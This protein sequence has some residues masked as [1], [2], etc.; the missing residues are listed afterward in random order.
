MLDLALER[1]SDYIMNITIV[2]ATGLV[3]EVFLDLLQAAHLP[4]DKLTLL[5]GSSAGASVKFADQDYT[6]QKLSGHDFAGT[7][8]VVFCTSAELSKIYVPLAARSGA[9]VIDLS[10]RFR[11]DA[12]VPLVIPEINA[13]V[14][15]ACPSSRVIA[16]PNCSTAQMLLPLAPLESS[17]GLRSINV[18]T[19]QSAS[20]AGRQLLSSIENNDT[21]CEL[22]ANVIAQIDAM[23]DNGYTREELKMRCETQKIFARPDL[24]ISATCVRVPVAIG[25]SEALQS[26]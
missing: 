14:L 1:E 23:T 22:H 24:T 4:L 21:S 20:G 12:A 6:V 13:A 9:L 16:N 17:F 10:S 11:N 2:G 15:G 19:Y 26:G 7:D 5:A 25:H 3:G 18:A 8:V